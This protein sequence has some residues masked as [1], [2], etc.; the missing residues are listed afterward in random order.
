M[1]S[2][3]AL[4]VELTKMSPA[5][6]PEHISLLEGKS[7]TCNIPRNML[8]KISVDQ[9]ESVFQFCTGPLKEGLYELIIQRM[10]S[11]VLSQ[12]SSI[13]SQIKSTLKTV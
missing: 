11:E 3:C 12:F 13:E 6:P 2:I 4:K 10:Y 7:M 1:D 5:A 9:L 8:S